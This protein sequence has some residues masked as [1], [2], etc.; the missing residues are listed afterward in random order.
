MKK[1]NCLIVISVLLLVGCNVKNSEKEVGFAYTPEA[2]KSILH[3]KIISQDDQPQ[4]EITVRLAK[5][6]YGEGEN[7]AFVLDEA[8]SPSTISE[9]DGSFLFLNIEP[10][11]YVIFIG[12]FHTKYKI[13]SEI[14]ES[15]IVYEI[16]LGEI[17]EIE[18][19]IADFN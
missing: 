11:D 9:A 17:L 5:V 19:I 12:K 7:G 15:P 8:N 2:G 3:G 18:P 14:D 4:T 6:Y 13:V 16:E 1:L 10:G